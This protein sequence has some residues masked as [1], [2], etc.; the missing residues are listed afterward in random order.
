MISVRI[1]IISY[2]INRN[3]CTARLL[4]GD[5]IEIDPFVGCAIPLTSDD[6][7]NGRGADCVGKDY[8]L[9]SYSVDKNQVVPN[10]GGMIEL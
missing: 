10:E 6:F 1:K 8:L 7:R 2:D 3:T 5:I 9:I 4:N